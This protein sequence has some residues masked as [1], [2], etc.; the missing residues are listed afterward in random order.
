MTIRRL[1]LLLALA[2]TGSVLALTPAVAAP[3]QATV[4]LPAPSST[5]PT[6]EVRSER[7]APLECTT[8]PP[9]SRAKKLA[10]VGD[11]EGKVRWCGGQVRGQVGRSSNGLVTSFDR[12]AKLD[13][14]VTLPVEGEGPW[15]LVVMLHGLGGS[16]DGNWRAAATYAARGY[17]VLDYTAR[18]YWEN[19]CESGTPSHSVKGAGNLYEGEREPSHA[20]RTQL[21]SRRYEIRDT[22]HLVGRFVD[23]SLV[24]GASANPRI[25]VMGTS[26]GG[27]QTWMLA[28]DNV[29]R[30]PRGVKVAV[31]A[32]VPVIGWTDLLDAL[33]PNGRASDVRSFV[34]KKADLD[35]RLAE[36]IGVLK[37]SYL[38]TFYLGMSS[39]AQFKLPG[40]LNSWH[41][42]VLAGEPYSDAGNPVMAEVARE[43]LRERS[44][45]YL[46]RGRGEPAILS[47]QGFTDTVFPAVQALNMYNLLNGGRQR[48]YPMNMYFGDYGHPVAQGKKAEAAYVDGLIEEWL[49]YYL[50][51]EGKRPRRIVE[52]RTT[53]C[54]DETQPGA[55]YRAKTWTDLQQDDEQAVDLAMKGK[56]DTDVDDV[57]ARIIK[58]IDSDAVTH[59]VNYAGCRV[60]DAALA[61][62]N[63]A[64]ATKTLSEPLTMLG[65]PTVSLMA[66]PE[67]EDMYIS[68]RLWDVDGDERTLVDRGVFRLQSA[69]QQSA[70][71]K[72]FG[73]AYTFAEGHRIELE[74]TAND[75]RSF[76]ESNAD[77]TIDVSDVTLSL[78]LA[79]PGAL[80]K[81]EQQ[82]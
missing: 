5:A 54:D 33:M 16:R 32:A 35:E 39:A 81:L 44:A 74:L 14:D 78:P 43:L 72:L 52:A 50:R 23:G 68:A 71:F 15:P 63:L 76:L 64:S 4:E 51:A 61:D 24:E 57:R 53:R 47:V 62:G 48:S 73:N 70:L 19:T 31:A 2:L 80:P 38:S 82:R 9:A 79:D 1:S 56:L 65:L 46:R 6:P 67:F 27:G 58:P 36:R 59:G 49:D 12:S 18:G 25:G 66:D 8:D 17:A 40:Y 77:G 45:L 26:Y 55:L 22:Q 30:S 37:E 34:K 75:T 29:W 69:N 20:C 13:V 7:G 41:E 60:T 3:R 21:A 10:K 11:F 42:A 28:R